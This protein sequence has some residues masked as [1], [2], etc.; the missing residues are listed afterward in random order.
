MLL[1]KV[2]DVIPESNCSQEGNSLITQMLR[3]VRYWSLKALAT[4]DSRRELCT[5]QPPQ[6]HNRKA[7]P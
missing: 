2:L 3:C 6:V 4:K 5:A 1:I 7:Q